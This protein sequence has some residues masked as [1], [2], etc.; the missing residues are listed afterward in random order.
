MQQGANWEEVMGRRHKI[1]GAKEWLKWKGVRS[2]SEIEVLRRNGWVDY[3]PGTHPFMS[4][5]S[6]CGKVC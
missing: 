5:G 4:G 3:A 6:Q 1:R 2:A